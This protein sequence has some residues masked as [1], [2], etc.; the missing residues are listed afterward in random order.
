MYQNLLLKPNEV[1][2]VIYH[3]RCSDGFTSAL[4][5][6]KYFKE[7][8]GVNSNGNVVEYH[9]AFFNQ[10]PPNVA[11][12]NVL[13]CDFSYKKPIMLELIAKA[14][15]LAIID[16]HES[17]QLE[18][19]DL[20][21][22]Y[23]VFDMFH[24]GAYLTWKYFYQNEDVP[25]FV[26]YV[27]DNDIWIKQMPQ[28]EEMTCF[29]YS[30]PFE[31]PEYEKLLD[32]SY[33]ETVAKPVGSGMKRQNDIYVKDAMPY[34]T[35]RLVKIGEEYYIVAY[36]N[37]TVLR[38]EI[39]NKI[40]TAYPYCD[41]SAVY[42]LNDD[43]TTFS[44][45]SSDDKTN[46]SQISTKFGGGGHRNASGMSVYNSTLLPVHH[47]DNGTM[48]KFLESDFVVADGQQTYVVANAGSTNPRILGK[49]L[50]QT[51]QEKI[52]K[53]ESRPLQKVCAILRTKQNDN[54]FYKVFSAC[55]VVSQNECSKNEYN[56]FCNSLELA[57][58]I[59]TN[60]VNNFKDIS[61]IEFDN[62]VRIVCSNDQISKLLDK[63]N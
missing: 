28:T 63:L 54:T 22:R 61:L 48:Y 31:F 35:N 23:K 20:D 30:L 13:I 59:H 25:L 33:I 7:S 49:Y 52:N 29:T 36:I 41:F 19:T 27:E 60:Y 6:Y 11:G 16:H 51:T 17:A 5:A 55:V 24:S 42:S 2:L 1:D 38:S 50:M 62:R 39:G 21:D 12:K 15:C 26:K 3:G 56:I 53:T 10:S 46:V 8:N 32:D 9:P 18:L 57:K 40:L 47:F 34:C 43:F 37:S 14:K 45:R 44:L 58:N 4:A